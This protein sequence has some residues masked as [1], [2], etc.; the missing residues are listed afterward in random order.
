M[1][2]LG[3]NMVK[4]DD[5]LAERLKDT[6]FKKAFEDA[7]VEIQKE[8]AEMKAKEKMATLDAKEQLDNY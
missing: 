2:K 7:D 3:G 6:E 4:F 5:Y 1:W 8:M